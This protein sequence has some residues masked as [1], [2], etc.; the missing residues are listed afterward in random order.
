MDGVRRGQY[1]DAGLGRYSAVAG[2]VVDV[3]SFTVC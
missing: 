2:F 3:T 1:I